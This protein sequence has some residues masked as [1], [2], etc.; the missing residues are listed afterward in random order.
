[1]LDGPMTDQ[2]RVPLI[3]IAT[4]C[5][6][7]LLSLIALVVV[8]RRS[9]RGSDPGALAFETSIAAAEVVKLERDTVEVVKEDGSV[10]GVRVTD[11]ALRDALGLRP[12]DVIAALAG[13]AIK[14]E[15]DIVDAVRGASSFDAEVLY[16][17][18]VRDGKPLLL[19]W[20]LDDSLRSVRKIDGMSRTPRDSS[21]TRDP[22]PN[23]FGSYG[24]SLTSRDPLL[25]TIRK[26]DDFHYEIP[27][28]TV[29]RALAN[30]MD[31]AKGARVVPG[32]SMGRTVGL[33]LYAVR[34]S[35][36]YA[37]LGF[38]NGDLVRTINGF[39]ISSMDKA[40]ELYTRLK[41]AT[42]LEIELTRRGREE[43]IRID[44]R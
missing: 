11:D 2:P 40:L 14:R 39:E 38:S 21:S 20:K 25:D 3:A 27:K 43:T 16:V 8:A 10:T 4:A 7:V 32:V 35:S 24:G 28:S 30:P 41:D 29:D 33:K 13:R 12:Y 23:P 15:L 18:V 36:I 17:D 5:V 26:L 31:F 44:I 1:M 42:S 22:L 37:A 19:R 34:P 9:T 6:A